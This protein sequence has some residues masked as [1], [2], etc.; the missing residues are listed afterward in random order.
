MEKDRS[1]GVNKTKKTEKKKALLAGNVAGF[2]VG[3]RDDMKVQKEP[4]QHPILEDT[5]RHCNE[6]CLEPLASPVATNNQ[7]ESTLM[8]PCPVTASP[9]CVSV[10]KGAGA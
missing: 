5:Y 7:G 9:K 10:Q 3:C 4:P 8:Y 1:D 6:E 2:V